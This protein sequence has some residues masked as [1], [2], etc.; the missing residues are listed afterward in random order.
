MNETPIALA[1]NLRAD[2]ELSFTTNGTQVANLRLAVPPASARARG[3]G[4]TAPCR[5]TASLA[6]A[7]S[8]PTPPTPSPR[9]PAWWPPGGSASASTRPRT[10]ARA[11]AAEVT[12]DDLGPSL[13]FATAKVHRAT[14]NGSGS[15]EPAARHADAPF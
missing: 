5:S 1:G 15:G 10:A 12:A 14:S 2:P 7:S 8:P 6:G 4:R 11:Q 3:P 13:L 9:A